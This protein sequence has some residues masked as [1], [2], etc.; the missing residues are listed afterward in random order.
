MQP[1]S[2]SLTRAPVSLCANSCCPSPPSVCLP[3]L[4]CRAAPV[5]CETAARTSVKVCVEE[6]QTELALLFSLSCS[7]NSWITCKR[8][9]CESMRMWEKKK[10]QLISTNAAGALK[11]P[12]IK[13]N[14]YLHEY[15]LTFSHV[16]SIT[17]QG[18]FIYLNCDSSR[19]LGGAL[20][21]LASLPGSCCAVCGFIQSM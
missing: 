12:M 4:L 19:P 21:V 5:R 9:V 15:H 17:K 8:T 16:S 13:Q 11:I 7:H 2:P 6:S 1:V 20:K 3:P 18:A 14:K 10:N